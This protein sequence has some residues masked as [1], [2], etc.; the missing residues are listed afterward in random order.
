MG[1]LAVSGTADQLAANLFELLGCLGEGD[2]LGRAD[3][4]E[5]EGVEEKDQIFALVVGQLDGLE[6]TVHHRRSRKVWSGFSQLQVAD[7]HLENKDR[8][9]KSKLS[10]YIYL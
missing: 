1:E 6:L 3:E 8:F 2:D 5:V 10:F 4:S 7:R 9:W